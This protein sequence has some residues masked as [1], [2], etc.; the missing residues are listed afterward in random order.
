MLTLNA[1]FDPTDRA[2]GKLIAQNEL[3]EWSAGTSAAF[4]VERFATARTTV[5]E[6]LRMRKLD[7]EALEYDLLAHLDPDKL[8]SDQFVEQLDALQ[9]AD[10]TTALRRYFGTGGVIREAEVMGGG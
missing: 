9:L 10:T 6:Q 2:A 8:G 4:S 3:R 7:F 5:R 1:T